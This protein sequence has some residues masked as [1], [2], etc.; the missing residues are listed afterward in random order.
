MLS[1]KYK[2]WLLKTLIHLGALL[3]VVVMYYLA[4]NDLLSADPV[5]D[6]IHFTGIGALNLL[7]ITLCVSPLARFFKLGF[8]LQVRRLLGLYAFFYALLH[9]NNFLFF[10]LQFDFSLF[11]DEIVDR[12]YITVGMLAF[13][14]IT[15]LAITSLTLLR[16][17]MGKTWQS[18]HNYNYVLTILVCIHFFWSVKSEIIEP[19]IYFIMLFV[20]LYLRKDKFKRWLKR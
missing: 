4:I 7:L 9:L 18:L 16:R 1:T 3:P 13:V 11:I 10:E 8:L 17:K 15:A 2:I 5:E 20:L 6:I 12:P 19:S 14:F